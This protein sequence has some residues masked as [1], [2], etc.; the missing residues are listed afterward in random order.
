MLVYSAADKS[1]LDKP[2]GALRI[3]DRTVVPNAATVLSRFPKRK[4]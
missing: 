4:K 3:G 2:L 1:K